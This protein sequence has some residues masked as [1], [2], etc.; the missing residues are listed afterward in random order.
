MTFQDE[1]AGDEAQLEEEEELDEEEADGE[2]SGS[3]GDESDEDE[4]DEEGEDAP[5]PK[6]R[7]ELNDTIAKAIR[8]G[9]G[10][11]VADSIAAQRR[12][13]SQGR[14]DRSGKDGKDGRRVLPARAPKTNEELQRT[15]ARLDGIELANAKRDF[16]YDYGLSPKQVDFVAK[17]DPKLSAKT[18][19]LPHIKA[20]LESMG[21]AAKARTNTPRT[22][23]RTFTSKDKPF[24]K[25]SEDE[26]RA[27]FG[28]HA[29]GLR[30]A[31]RERR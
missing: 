31:N 19:E 14:D 25:L 4:A 7:K 18:L 16:G 5:L 29:A 1:N 10:K 30:A 2:E 6:T 13:S 24:A 27:N 23:G 15:N 20:A 8:K 9:V 11:A 22:S 28:E 3:K 17:F 26:K 21:N 12:R